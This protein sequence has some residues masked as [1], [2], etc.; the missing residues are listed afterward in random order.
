MTLPGPSVSVFGPQL[1]NSIAAL[2]VAALMVPELKTL[3]PPLTL[4]PMPPAPTV[5][6]P[7]LMTWFVV[8]NELTSMPMPAA[9]RVIVPLLVT[10]LESPNAR[11]PSAKSPPVIRPLL[12]IVVNEPV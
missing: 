12:V 2:P 1:Q 7:V 9:P 5:M 11:M 8:L 3:P 4:M 6:E 10:V